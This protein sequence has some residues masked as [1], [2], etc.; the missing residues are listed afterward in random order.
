MKD[1]EREKEKHKPSRPLGV[2]AGLAG[3][4][5]LGLVAGAAFFFLFFLSRRGGASLSASDGD[6]DGWA[7]FVAPAGS[8]VFKPSELNQFNGEDGK[9]FYLAVLGQVFDVTKGEQFYG[10]DSHYHGFIGY[11]NGQQ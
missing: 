2:D 6:G 3:Y 1:R 9:P 8:L 5:L 4:A 11:A 7:A 10:K